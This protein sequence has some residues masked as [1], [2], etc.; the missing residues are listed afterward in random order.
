[1]KQFAQLFAVVLL[2]AVALAQTEAAKPAP[3]PLTESQKAFNQLKALEGVWEGKMST[4]PPTPE[5]EGHTAIVTLRVMSRGNAVAHD[6]RVDGI[7]DNPLTVFYRND[8]Q[9]QLVHY[10]DAGNRPRM[11]G[12]PAPDGKSVAYDFVDITGPTQWGHMYRSKFTFVDADHHVEEWT[13]MKPDKQP[14]LVR[15]ELTRRK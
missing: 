8:D 5:V 6:L 4:Q 1:M 9:L 14:V 11:T 10:C 15:L 2:A 13:W 3:K 12:Q 7:P